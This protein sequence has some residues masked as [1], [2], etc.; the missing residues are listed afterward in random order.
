MELSWHTYIV[1]K[2]D[3]KGAVV[4]MG[5]AEY[6]KEGDLQLNIQHITKLQKTKRRF[7]R[8]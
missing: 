6:I 3:K 1:A 5:V 4:I 8:R 2:K 7:H